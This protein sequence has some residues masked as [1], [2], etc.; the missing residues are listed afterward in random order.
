MSQYSAVYISERIFIIATLCMF[1]SIKP[2]INYEILYYLIT[3][4]ACSSAFL[5]SLSSPLAIVASAAAARL[6]RGRELPTI[7]WTI[8][9]SWNFNFIVMLSNNTQRLFT[10]IKAIIKDNNFTESI[11]SLNYISPYYFFVEYL[12]E[13][14]IKLQQLFMQFK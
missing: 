3:F 5:V 11:S 9:R 2:T 10:L 8:K 6:E 14:T 4:A 12:L 13:G 7:P 1:M